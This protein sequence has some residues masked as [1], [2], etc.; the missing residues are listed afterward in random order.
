[1]KWNGPFRVT[2]CQEQLIFEVENLLDGKKE[3]VHGRRL[4]LFRN[5]DFEVSED[6]KDHLAYQ[7]SK[8][9]VIE[10]CEDIRSRDN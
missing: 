8:V 1:M 5:K 4:K 6:I 3:L 2:A 10:D 7:Q 9:L